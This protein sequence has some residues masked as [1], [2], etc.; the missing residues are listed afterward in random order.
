MP[1]DKRDVELTQKGLS[2][3]CNATNPQAVVLLNDQHRIS[4]PH[5]LARVE[6]DIDQISVTEYSVPPCSEK[7]SQASRDEA[8]GWDRNPTRHPQDLRES[9]YSTTSEPSK[10]P[11]GPQF[12]HHQWIQSWLD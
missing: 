8:G 1:R 2:F 6:N 5:T 7:A 10:G 12:S 9:P 3:P 4:S 11:L